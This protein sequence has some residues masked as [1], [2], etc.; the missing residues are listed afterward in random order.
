[1]KWCLHYIDATIRDTYHIKYRPRIG[2]RVLSL[3]GS[4][5]KPSGIHYHLLHVVNWLQQ[6]S[7]H[8]SKHRP[9]LQPIYTIYEPTVAFLGLPRPLETKYS[10]RSLTEM[11]WMSDYD[12]RPK[13]KVRAGSPNECQTFRRTSTGCY[14]LGWNNAF[15]WWEHWAARKCR[16]Y[17][18]ARTHRLWWEQT[19]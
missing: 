5:Q 2:I 10:R 8:H 18:W 4:Q 14:M 11:S 12:I 16:S 3:V 7:S 13:P 15:Y 1:M 17:T 19:M 9:V 6:S